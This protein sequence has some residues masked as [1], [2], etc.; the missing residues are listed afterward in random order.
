MTLSYPSWAFGLR[1][2]E[3]ATGHLHR[4]EWSREE[5]SRLEKVFILSSLVDGMKIPKLNA[6]F[7]PFVILLTRRQRKSSF[8]L[9]RANLIVINQRCDWEFQTPEVDHS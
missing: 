4:G 7:L 8:W 6:F 9:L 5:K 3:K 2:N 1:C